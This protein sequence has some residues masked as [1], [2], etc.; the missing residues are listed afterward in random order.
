MF[1]PYHKK[2]ITDEVKPMHKNSIKSVTKIKEYF[3]YPGIGK[4]F[5]IKTQNAKSISGNADHLRKILL[6][7][8]FD[9]KSKN[10]TVK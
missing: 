9:F 8:R 6:K 5:L 7:P 10:Q 2:I 3:Y 4:A 1:L